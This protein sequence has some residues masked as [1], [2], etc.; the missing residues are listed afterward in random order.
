MWPFGLPE[1]PGP[2]L[3]PKREFV[4][5]ACGFWDEQAP[6]HPLRELQLLALEAPTSRS[7]CFVMA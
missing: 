4:A 1:E 2:W 5:L 3:R 6:F 7:I